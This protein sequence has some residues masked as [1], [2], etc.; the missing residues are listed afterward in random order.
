[1]AKREE[2]FAAQAK[3]L[4]AEGYRRF[5]VMKIP[6]SRPQDFLAE[7]FKT[8]DQMLKVRA[9]IVDEQKRIGIVDERRRNQANA[10]FGKQTGIKRQELKAKEKKKTLGDIQS[11]KDRKDKNNDEGKSLEAVL[12][13]VNQSQKKEGKGKG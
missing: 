11:W 1:M 8:D 10:K 13:G 9:K 12:A 4:V 5:R 2:A 6:A 3:E 7:M